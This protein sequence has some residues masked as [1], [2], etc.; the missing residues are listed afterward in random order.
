VAYA[1]T[2]TTTYRRDDRGF[3]VLAV[4]CYELGE[5]ARAGEASRQ[6]LALNPANEVARS[7][8]QAIAT[9]QGR[10]AAATVP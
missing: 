6:A 5:L 7:V 10:G 4:A 9:Q 8:L 3:M 1:T 2:L